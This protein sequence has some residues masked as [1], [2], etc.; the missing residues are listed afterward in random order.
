MSEDNPL[1]LDSYT[2]ERPRPEDLGL[3][4]TPGSEPSP[5]PIRITLHG[6]CFVVCAMDP[7]IMI[8]DLRLKDFELGS[9]QCTIVGYLY[10][11]PAE[12]SIVSIQYGEGYRAEMAEPF[13]LEKLHDDPRSGTKGD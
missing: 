8:G 11:L 6:N 3:T 13:T 9:D 4:A 2:L 10:E 12:G 5:L 7:T 1:R